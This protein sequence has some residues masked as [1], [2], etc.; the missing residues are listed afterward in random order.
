M[1]GL[2]E[3]KKSYYI[4]ITFLKSF[5]KIL[6]Y[7]LFNTGKKVKNMGLKV[8]EFV[9]QVLG[10]TL[11]SWKSGFSNRLS[12]TSSAVSISIGSGLHLTMTEQLVKLRN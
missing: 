4:F 12:K 11:L 7:E 2:S 6:F 1:S 9:G 8:L 10:I 5:L 3:Q